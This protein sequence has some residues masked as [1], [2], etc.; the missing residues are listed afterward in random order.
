MLETYHKIVFLEVIFR[1]IV[2]FFFNFGEISPNRDKHQVFHIL[3]Y[4]ADTE[5]ETSLIS[6]FLFKLHFASLSS[7]A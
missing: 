7:V 5:H 2:R 4:F 3:E 6:E 1:E